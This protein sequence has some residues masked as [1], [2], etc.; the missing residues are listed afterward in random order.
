MI[1]NF[2]QMEFDIV[3]EAGQSNCVG[4]GYGDAIDPYEPIK[5]VWSLGTNGVISPAK[6]DTLG[7]HVRGNMTL[8]FSRKYVQNGLLKDDRN[9][10]IIRSAVGGAGFADKHWGKN[11][12]YFL[13]MLKMTKS[14]LALNPKNKVVGILWHQGEKD[15][16]EYMKFDKHYDNLSTLLTLTRQELDDEK[17]PFIMGDFVPDWKKHYGY[18]CEPIRL[19]MMEVNKNFDKTYFVCSDNLESNNENTDFRDDIVHFC[20]QSLYVLGER[21]FDAFLE[22]ISQ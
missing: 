12:D 18:E 11:D 4:Y 17:I 21:Y 10:L 9:L 14:A 16:K 20:R 22:I 5:T 2:N 13:R 19:A 6:E 15:S 3:I 1:K 8:S 7:N